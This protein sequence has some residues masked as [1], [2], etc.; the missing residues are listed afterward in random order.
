M[1]NRLAQLR[2]ERGVTQEALAHALGISR[3]S[4][5]ALERG[6]YDPSI[7]VAFRAARYFGLAIEEVFLY[8]SGAAP[9]PKP[10]KAKPQAEIPP[11]TPEPQLPAREPAVPRPNRGV[12]VG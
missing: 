12:R 10:S 8:D 9:V 6:R 1:E 2:R 5:N 7:Q 3:Q 4:V 11:P